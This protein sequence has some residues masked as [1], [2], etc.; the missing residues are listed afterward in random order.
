MQTRLMQASQTT[1]MM[2]RAPT[3]QQ[4][5]MKEDKAAKLTAHAGQG[6]CGAECC[7]HAVQQVEVVLGAFASIG[8]CTG[9]FVAVAS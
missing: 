6:T 4:L 7:C 8:G 1:P 2:D 5:L 9:R 3:P